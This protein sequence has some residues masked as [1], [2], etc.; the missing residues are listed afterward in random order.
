MTLYQLKGYSVSK[1]LHF[2]SGVPYLLNDAL[3]LSC[4]T[5]PA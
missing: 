5:V 1:A 2:K 4:S 3:N